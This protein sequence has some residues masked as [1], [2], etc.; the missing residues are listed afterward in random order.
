MIAEKNKNLGKKAEI[1]RKGSFVCLIRKVMRGLLSLH[2]ALKGHLN[3]TQHLQM[4]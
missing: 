1:A 2:P 4:H 3:N